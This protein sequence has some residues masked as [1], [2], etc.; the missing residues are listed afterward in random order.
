MTVVKATHSRKLR[1]GRLVLLPHDQLQSSSSN[2]N[3]RRCAL[4]DGNLSDAHHFDFRPSSMLSSSIHHNK[5]RAP[6]Y[7]HHGALPAKSVLCYLWLLMF[8][9]SYDKYSY[10]TQDESV[11]FDFRR[12]MEIC[13]QS[14]HTKNLRLIYYP[15]QDS[16]KSVFIRAPGEQQQKQTAVDNHDREFSHK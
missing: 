8:L 15:S 11:H 7:H 5:H 4:N 2:H 13:H 10:I 6:P 1:K 9:W 16:P 12:L 3:A 14:N